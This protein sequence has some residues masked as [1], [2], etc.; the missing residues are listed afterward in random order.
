LKNK[1]E[2]KKL[3]MLI[4]HI[5]KWKLQ[6]K[7]LLDCEIVDKRDITIS[8]LQPIRAENVANNVVR[9]ER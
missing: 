2:K 6:L 3:V 4:I 9:Q 8:S 5:D 7:S 1:N